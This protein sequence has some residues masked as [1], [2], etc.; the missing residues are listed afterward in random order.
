MTHSTQ[1]SP[2]K[3]RRLDLRI[4]A[5]IACETVADAPPGTFEPEIVQAV[6]RAAHASDVSEFYIKLMLM[7]ATV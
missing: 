7:M 2:D 1:L 4:T 3:R 6:A 5:Q